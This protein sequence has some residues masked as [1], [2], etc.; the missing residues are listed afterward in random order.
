MMILCF[1]H[2]VYLHRSHY[3]RDLGDENSDDEF[4]CLNKM[5]YLIIS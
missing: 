5:K 3:Y 2:L 4:G 1:E